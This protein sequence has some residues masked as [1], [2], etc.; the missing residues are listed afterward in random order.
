MHAFQ[1]DEKKGTVTPQLAQEVDDHRPPPPTDD[2]APQGS[3][4]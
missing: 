4:L 3:L 1:F 2:D